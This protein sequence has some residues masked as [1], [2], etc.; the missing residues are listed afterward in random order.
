MLMRVVAVK[1]YDAMHG[2]STDLAEVRR[3]LDA[4]ATSELDG[5][6]EPGLNPCRP[7]GAAPPT[8]PLSRP[9]RRRG[10]AGEP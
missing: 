2:G 8:A 5:A 7:S 6:H 1:V 10:G 4:A 9:W 3:A